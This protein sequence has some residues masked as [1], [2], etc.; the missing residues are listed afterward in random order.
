MHFSTKYIR[1]SRNSIAVLSGKETHEDLEN[2]GK[3]IFT[4]F[5]L[6]CRNVSKIFV[7]KD[8]NFT[9]FFEAIF[10]FNSIINANKYANNYDYN[11]TVYLM[12]AIPLLDNNFVILKD[13]TAMASPLGVVF[14]EYYNNLSDVI[15][16]IENQQDAIQC[17]VSNSIPNTIGFGNTQKPSLLDYADSLDTMVFLNS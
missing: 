3:D 11:K 10:P 17:V 7:P 13:D 6:G 14:Y 15:K 5:G 4:Y 8:Y 2:L 9:P 16:I 1:K 12:N